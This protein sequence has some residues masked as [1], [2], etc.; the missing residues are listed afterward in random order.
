VT[1]VR[2]QRLVNWES[3]AAGYAS[4]FVVPTATVILLKSIIIQNGSSAAA[5][6]QV[7][8]YSTG[9][10]LYII[11]QELTIDEHIRWD[12]WL[13]MNPDDGA[14]VYAGQPLMRVWCSGAVLAGGPPYPTL[15]TREVPA[16]LPTLSRSLPKL[17]RFE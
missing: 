2:S 12:G 8:V 15:P 1:D 3:T 9:P 14:W 13:A 5:L 4:L 10:L 7:S 16:S 11:N 17:T 6:I